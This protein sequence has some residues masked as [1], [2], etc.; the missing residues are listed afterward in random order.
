LPEAIQ[1]HLWVFLFWKNLV[2]F[3]QILIFETRFKELRETLG[4]VIMKP[5]KYLFM[6]LLISPVYISGLY[7]CEPAG[8]DHVDRPR[9]D[10]ISGQVERLVLS[11]DL[12][13]TDDERLWWMNHYTSPIVSMSEQKKLEVSKGFYSAQI[14]AYKAWAKARDIPFIPTCVKEE[15]ERDQIYPFYRLDKMERDWFCPK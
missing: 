11:Q 7:A 5:K 10:T 4:V 1:V 8:E 9:G 15:N 14:L 2:F 12:E 6:V 13:P 3:R